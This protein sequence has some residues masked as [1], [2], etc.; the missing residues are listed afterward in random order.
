MSKQESLS[1]HRI[2]IQKL[3]NHPASFDE[4]LDKFQSESELHELNLEVSLRTFQRDLKEIETLYGIEIKFDRSRKVYFI[5]EDQQ[6]EYSERMFEALDVFQV[7]NLNQSFSEFI[8]FD[9]RKPEGT[10]NLSGL[11]YAIQNRFQ[12]QFR[13]QKFWSE[14][15][16]I[17]TVEPY[18]LKE[19]KKRWYVFVYDL[20]RKEFRTFGLDRLFALQITQTKF[21]FPQKI[22][23]KEFFKDCFGIVGPGEKSP[24][25]IGLKF[26]NGQGNYIRTM[27]LHHSQQILQDKN[28]EMIVQLK[29][30]PT[31]DFVQEILS[32][33]EFIQVLQPKSL[34]DEIQ[35]KLKTALK[36]YT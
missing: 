33:G 26:I 4:I 9:T 18:L 16:E 32:H 6:D 14:D 2:I 5:N 30:V 35:N 3:R 12:I 20:E 24:Q 19:F 1:R 10:E 28:G 7:L 15:V 27:P 23:A 31:Y 11:L 29:I 22:N 34:A 36:L 21:Q 8:Q 13:Y 17:R 25:I